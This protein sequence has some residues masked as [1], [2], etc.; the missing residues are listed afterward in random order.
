VLSC[1][2]AGDLASCS[3][4]SEFWFV[5]SV[6]PA[7][8]GM[9]S[10]TMGEKDIVGEQFVGKNKP[11]AGQSF[12][13]WVLASRAKIAFGISF[14]Y[15]LLIFV[16]A[17]WTLQGKFYVLFLAELPYLLSL[18][19]VL[20][21][22]LL[23]Y[24]D[25]SWKNVLLLL[26]AIPVFCLCVPLTENPFL[27]V[28]VGI[29][30]IGDIVLL[31]PCRVSL[32]LTVAFCLVLVMMKRP[33]VVWGYYL[34]PMQLLTQIEVFSLL[35]SFGLVLW[36]LIALAEAE[37]QAAEDFQRSNAAVRKLAESNVRLQNYVLDI[38]KKSA[39]DERKRI[40]RE[41]HDTVG[42][43]LTNIRMMADA[44][45]RVMQDDKEKT[46]VLLFQIRDQAITGIQE[47]RQAMRELRNLEQHPR[48][49][50][51]RI[52]HMVGMFGEATGMQVSLEFGNIPSSLSPELFRAIYR[53][54]QEGLTNAFKHGEASR[55]EIIFNYFKPYL[56][57]TI[58]DNGS[59]SEQIV[60][61][62]GFKGMRERI[63]PYA[64][65]FRCRNLDEG[66]E[67]NIRMTVDGVDA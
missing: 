67:V 23:V 59:G 10:V 42:Y 13:G 20:S 62:I 49:W 4:P 24:R 38:E 43:T 46:Q 16:I 22:I 65:E 55:V 26:K 18:L 21:L 36:L 39:D 58:R 57:L 25:R 40:S 12:H 34:P 50:L 27:M 9:V 3:R 52:N 2:E 14:V 19:M 45:L 28:L 56:S 64:G 51:A 37:Q 44:S 8:D 66:Y 15:Y 31:F 32:W 61:G 54:V 48:P 63:A 60:E 47:T 1:S 29:S 11:G 41:I 6:V 33:D 17:K 5:W 7:R 30:V 53:V 35:L